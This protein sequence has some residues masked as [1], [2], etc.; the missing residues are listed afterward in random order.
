MR[1]TGNTQ[2]AGRVINAYKQ[3]YVEHKRVMEDDGRDDPSQAAVG[4]LYSY[5]VIHLDGWSHV[6]FSLPQKQL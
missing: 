4:A 1:A 3:I 2:F 5:L 6:F